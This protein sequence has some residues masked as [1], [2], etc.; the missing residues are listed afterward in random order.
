[1]KKSFL[2]L[3]LLMVFM[4]TLSWQSVAQDNQGKR[5][6]MGGVPAVAYD[7]DMGFRYG[8]LANFYDHGPNLELYPFYR[9]SIYVEWSHTTKGNDIKQLKYDSEYL[10][11][12]VRLTALARLETE[13]AIDFYGFNGYNS[14]YNPLF[15]DATSTDYIS[16]MYYR[17]GY[18]ALILK[19]DFQGDLIK[20][21]LKWYGGLK[22][23][24]LDVGRVDITRLNE[25]NP[26]NLIPDVPTLYDEYV[27]AGYIPDAEKDGGISASLTAGVVFDTRDKEANPN[28]GIWAEAVLMGSP[29][30]GGSSGYTGIVLTHRHY[31]PIITNKL[32][33]AYRLNYQTTFTGQVPWYALHFKPDSYINWTGLGGSKTLRGIMRN[34]IVGQG[35]ALGN[36]EFRWKFAQFK[37]ANQDVYLALVPFVDAGMITKE[38]ALQPNLSGEADGIHWSYGSGLRIAL[39]ENFIVA[40]DYGLAADKRDGDSGLYIGLDFLF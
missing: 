9:H 3:A 19:A 29:G 16:R 4:I 17:M 24:K 5:W 34:R 8:A 12:G 30:I 1:M 35:S 7:A 23:L 21:K 39:N 27:T 2:S 33:F 22:M 11:P 31:L 40:V 18:Q 10:I 15:E 36:F 13:Q 28:R 20:D 26:Y 32:I 38:Y 25:R 6:K 37:V 14:I